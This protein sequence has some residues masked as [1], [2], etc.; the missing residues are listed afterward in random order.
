MATYPFDKHLLR[1]ELQLA[2]N[3][4]TPD[5]SYRVVAEGLDQ[6]K[7]LEAAQGL[8]SGLDLEVGESVAACMSHVARCMP[9]VAFHMSHVPCC[10]LQ[11]DGISYSVMGKSIVVEVRLQ[12]QNQAMK[13]VRVMLPLFANA[14]LVGIVLF[15]FTFQKHRK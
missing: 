14:M 5:D 2:D 8:Y 9:H 3:F 11:V 6:G 10:M 1:A 7:V 12:R 4:A 13:F 15:I